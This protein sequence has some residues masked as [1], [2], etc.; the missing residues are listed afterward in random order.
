MMM[1]IT[2]QRDV[3]VVSM[4]LMPP[5][6]MTY[7]KRATTE[8]QQQQQLAIY[9]IKHFRIVICNWKWCRDKKK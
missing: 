5:F 1:M 6:E 9:S 2:M 7:S 8:E 3:S 4:H